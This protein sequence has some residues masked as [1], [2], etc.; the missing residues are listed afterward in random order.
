VVADEIFAAGDTKAG[1]QTAAFTL[2]NDERV[3][4]ARGTKKVML[5]NVS[6]A[7]FETVLVGIADSV[8]LPQDRAALAFDPFFTLILMHELAHGLGPGTIRLPDG[9]ETDLHR[10]LK[11]FSPILEEAKADVLGLWALSQLGR[12][13]AF[14]P[15]FVRAAYLSHIPNIVRSVRFG[16]TDAHGRANVIQ[17]NSFVERGALQFDPGTGRFRVD[18]GKM[19]QA[20]EALARAILTVQGQGSY[21]GARDLVARYGGMPRDLR[22]TTGRL[23]EVP[24]DIWPR[25]RAEEL[26]RLLAAGP[27]GS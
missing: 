6:R 15:E 11:E 2:P 26:G 20:P 14:A 1:V 19:T 17:F 18:Y 12:R 3:R 10:A 9:S 5:R 24:V 22:T 23:T 16:V 21:D 4:A 27:T 25:F 8:M 7:K 13:K